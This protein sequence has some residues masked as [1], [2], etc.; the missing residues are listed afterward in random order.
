MAPSPIP[1]TIDHGN[2]G[3]P[4]TPH[5]ATTLSKGWVT[6]PN[7]RG[8]LDILWTCASTL[9]I[10][11][12]VQ[13]HLNVPG[14]HERFFTQ[15]LRRLRWLVMGALVPEVLLLSAGGQWASAERSVQDMKRLFPNSN[16]WTIVHG[17][18]ADSGGFVLQPRDSDPFPVS[19][20]QVHYLVENAYIELPS[21]TEKEI[22]DKS[23]GDKF[24][25][26]I[27]CLQTFWFI[28]QC[29]ARLIQRLPVSPLELQTCS[30]IICTVTTYFLWLYKPLSVQTPT[31]IPM[32]I[33]IGLV[34]KCAGISAS[35]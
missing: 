24:T 15:S 25:K 6:Q 4:Y 3:I 19:A 32:S 12:W 2:G 28:T 18:Y 21:I 20:K 16:S 9:F 23:K 5:N 10:C 26:T 34:L 33:P 1:I 14:P 17:F 7:N 27:A 31:V 22:L 8:T 30:I 13:L 11:L 35:D 29:V